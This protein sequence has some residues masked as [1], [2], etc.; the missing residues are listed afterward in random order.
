MGELA[1]ALPGLPVHTRGERERDCS[2][3]LTSWREQLVNF[4]I[5]NYL[6]TLQCSP[7]GGLSFRA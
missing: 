1:R 3:A 4:S 7:A 5:P 2:S 6:P